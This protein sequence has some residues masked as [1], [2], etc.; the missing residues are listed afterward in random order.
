MHTVMAWSNQLLPYLTMSNT[1]L[2]IGLPAPPTSTTPMIVCCPTHC[3]THLHYSSHCLL[4]CHHYFCNCQLP[5][6][7]PHPLP[8][9]LTFLTSKTLTS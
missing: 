5:C 9:P 2:F 1:P 3:P 4:P 6:P 7:L 8:R